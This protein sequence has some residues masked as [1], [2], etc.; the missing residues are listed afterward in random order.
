MD[1][2]SLVNNLSGWTLAKRPI[3]KVM[4]RTG[5]NQSYEMG[6]IMVRLI[7]Y[8]SREFTDQTCKVLEQFAMISREISRPT[9]IKQIIMDEADKMV[10]AEVKV[11]VKIYY[12]L[13]YLRKDTQITLLFTTM[14]DKMLEVTF[15]QVDGIL[16]WN[17][18]NQA[19]K[20]IQNRLKDNAIVHAGYAF[21]EYKAANMLGRGTKIKIYGEFGNQNQKAKTIMLSTTKSE[22]VLEVSSRL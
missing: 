21:D 8:Q 13:R 6:M 17:V 19:S 18:P 12:V 15:S 5:G 2:H 14:P 16:N 20:F 4:V 1:C 22:K 7:R 3:V 9:N 10:N 11:K